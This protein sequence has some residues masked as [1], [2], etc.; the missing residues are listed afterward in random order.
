V[1]IWGPSAKLVAENK[2]I[3]VKLKELMANGVKLNACITCAN[4]YDVAD[5]VF[6]FICNYSKQ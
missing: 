5:I 1:I 4:M 3:Q 2:E 6:L